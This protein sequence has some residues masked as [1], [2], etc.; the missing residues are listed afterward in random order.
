[1]EQTKQPFFSVII[2][3]YNR[4]ALIARALETLL[5]QTETDWE[6]LIIDDGS[7]DGTVNIV[8]GFIKENP[9]IHLFTQQNQ[10]AGSAKNFGIHK[11]KGKYITFLDS[12]DEYKPEHLSF[13]KS[14]ILKNPNIEFIHGTADIIGNPYV[15]DFN[16]PGQII[17]LDNC[18][19]GGTFV[20]NR[21]IITKTGGYS[22]LK[23]GD[24]ISFY[25]LVRQLK[26]NIAKI[27][28]KT[29]IYH[30]DNDDSICNNILK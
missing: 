14:H 12:D 28:F 22:T 15:P 30:R 17:H 11:A 13:I 9:D 2:T 6:A 3:A 21:N 29:Y 8:N 25:N 19:I 23:F 20:I 7:S 5:S 26:V 27:D 18:I 10:G 24:D 4:E 16:N 1:M